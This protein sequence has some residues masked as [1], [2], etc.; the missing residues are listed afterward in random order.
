MNLCETNSKL[1]ANQLTLNTKTIIIKIGSYWSSQPR[2]KQEKIQSN[3]QFLQ[4]FK[5]FRDLCLFDV[6]FFKL[7]IMKYKKSLFFSRIEK[8]MTRTKNTSNKLYDF[9]P[10]ERVGSI[11][12]QRVWQITR[13]RPR[14]TISGCLTQPSTQSIK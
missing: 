14:W 7:N 9:Y 4:T 3:W 5:N 1:W 6:Y 11:L 10:C 12:R 8:S 2:N 13:H